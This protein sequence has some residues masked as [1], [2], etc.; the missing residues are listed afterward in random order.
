MKHAM[1]LIVGTVL[2]VTAGVATGAAKADV[3]PGDVKFADGSVTQSLTG[4]PGDP[5]MGRDWF[6]GRKLGN[7]LACHTNSELKDQP[8]HGEVGP[9]LDGV[10]DRWNA[11]QLRAILVNSKTVFGDQ[12]I[13]PAFY[14]DS[15]FNRT[16]EKFEGM[17]ILTAQQIEDVIAYLLT[18]KE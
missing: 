13:M 2:A 15:G 14:R 17:T 9:T 11:G 10:A 8:F 18:L 1:P 4:Q 5:A 7:C 12:T 16:A 6:A 3:A